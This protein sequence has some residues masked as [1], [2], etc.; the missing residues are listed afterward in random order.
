MLTIINE[1]LRRIRR[2]EQGVTAIEYVLLAALIAVAI[3]GGVVAVGGGL[4][5]TFNAVAGSLP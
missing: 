1:L 3:I 4:N 5:N 2:D